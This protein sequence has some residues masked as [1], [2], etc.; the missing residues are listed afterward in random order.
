MDEDVDVDVAGDLLWEGEVGECSRYSGTWGQV[1]AAALAV[2]QEMN[3]GGGHRAAAAAEMGTTITT[4]ATTT[5]KGG[6][7]RN[8]SQCKRNKRM[9]A[10]WAQSCRLSKDSGRN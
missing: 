5:A 4:K 1:L 3:S 9:Q 10:Q 2:Q 8:S 7:K 6:D